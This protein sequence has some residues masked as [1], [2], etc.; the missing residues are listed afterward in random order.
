MAIPPPP[1]QEKAQPQQ[2]TSLLDEIISMD[3]DLRRE[4]DRAVADKRLASVYCPGEQG[5]LIVAWGRDFGWQAAQAAMFIDCISGK[6]AL[7]AVARQNLMKKAGYSWQPVQ[8]DDTI[9]KFKFF[10]HGKV[11]TNADGTPM[12]LAFT[13]AEATKAGYVDKSRGKEGKQGNYDKIPK[14][15]LLA[16]LMANFHRW[17]ASEVDGCTLLDPVE[18]MD[19]VIN[20]TEKN[21]MEKS[22]SKLD[23]LAAE[24]QAV[25]A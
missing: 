10:H 1:P 6:P 13:F 17:Y 8:H 22:N 14:N 3:P 12:E 15:M 24:I 20:E 7:K 2:G 23:Q 16:R 18:I 21:I 11:M 5:A 25:R 9:A 4:L 19:E